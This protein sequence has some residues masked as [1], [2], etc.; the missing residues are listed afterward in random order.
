MRETPAL[1]GSA[2]TTLNPRPDRT[3]ALLVAGV[4]QMRDFA[5]AEHQDGFEF[6]ATEAKSIL[7]ERQ[8]EWA[9]FT[10]FVT[11]G[12]GALVVLLVLMLLF[13]A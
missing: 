10:Q 4:W 8:A 2:G 1:A 5:V 9:R 3:P 12:I 7:A 6:S 13:V 11:W